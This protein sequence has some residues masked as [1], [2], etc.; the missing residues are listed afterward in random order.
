MSSLAHNPPWTD[1]DALVSQLRRFVGLD[2]TELVMV[3]RYA[4]ALG[5]EA[6]EFAAQFYHYLLSQPETARVFAALT[7]AQQRALARHQ[8][9]HFRGMLADWPACALNDVAAVAKAHH[10]H[11]IAATWIAGAYNMYYEHLE[12]RL[13]TVSAA[14]REALRRAVSR[15]L[16]CDLMLQLAALENAHSEIGAE[17]DAI[18]R[19]LLDTTLRLADLPSPEDVFSNIC[20]Q[21]VRRS[22]HLPAV[23][24][25]LHDDKDARLRPFFGAGCAALWEHIDVPRRPGEPLWDALERNRGV[26]LKPGGDVAVPDW[27]PRD[28]GIEAAAVFPF[29]RS[30]GIRGLGVVFADSTWYFDQIDIYPFE[31]FARLGEVLL[32]IKEN[33]LRDP[34]TGLPNRTLFMDRLQQG[35]AQAR[36]R[37]KLLGVGMIDLDGFKEINDR[38]GHLNGDALLREVAARFAGCMRRGDTIARLGGDEFGLVLADLHDV[39]EA[40]S[41]VARVLGSLHCPIQLEGEA[42][43]VDASLGLTLYPLDDTSGRDLLRHADMALYQ[44]KDHGRR[45]YRFYEFASGTRQDRIMELQRDFARALEADELVFQFQPKVDIALGHVVGV[46]ALV[47]WQRGDTLLEPDAFIAAV[48]ASPRLIEGLGRHALECAA[49]QARGWLYNGRHIPIAVNIGAEH[50]LSPRFIEDVDDVLARHP[51]VG[52]CLEI[53]I[54]EHAAQRDL[55]RARSALEACIER[56]LSVALDDYGTGHASLT[57]LQELPSTQIKLDKRFVQK[58]LEEP[59]ALA[60][61]AGNLTSANL[62]DLEVVAEGVETLEQGELLLQLG[63]RFA[64]G[65][66]IARPMSADAL[67]HWLGHWQ[68]PDTWAQW[69][70]NLFTQQDL[71][72]LMAR[73]AHRHN[74]HAL[75]E[76]LATPPTPEQPFLLIDECVDEARCALGRWL[77]GAGRRYRALPSFAPLAD[78]HVETHAQAIEATLAWQSRDAAA[79]AAEITR[80]RDM[81]GEMDGRILALARE[82]GIEGGAG[83][84]AG[85]E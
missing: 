74:L 84:G 35:L 64:Q 31:A 85:N 65:Y 54:T 66:A 25:A 27:W 13:A 48:E 73:T 30:E 6:D 38:L 70:D 57:H 72:F 56:G 8:A 41:T 34:L 40:E 49:A 83:V 28:A 17:R 46:E 29:G 61:I 55:A 14:A 22:R 77:R 20:T 59:R 23:W 82:I 33:Q 80:L 44:A 75:L 81:A 10:A 62:L 50:L 5:A 53:E 76:A 37:Q 36:R 2:D 68:P 26:V 58:L 67:E 24:F 47:R 7:P 79:I 78:L 51:G 12:T 52:S 42:V 69:R 71:P 16:M 1:A 19:I 32:R 18:T 63:C 21:L 11:G 9:E 43:R 3:R 15:L 60:I 39:A 4:S 45:G